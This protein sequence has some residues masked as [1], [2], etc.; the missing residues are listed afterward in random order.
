MEATRLTSRSQT[1]AFQTTHVRFKAAAVAILVL[2]AGTASAQPAGLT[3]LAFS[4]TNAPGTDGTF[5]SFGIQKLVRPVI[6]NN[7][8]VAFLATLTGGSV[9]SNNDQALYVIRNAT[10]PTI[11]TREG[12]ATSTGTITAIDSFVISNAAIAY[13]LTTNDGGTVLQQNGGLTTSTLAQTGLNGWLNFTVSQIGPPTINSN[14]NVAAVVQTT[15]GGNASR[16]GLMNGFESSL[17]NALS[18]GDAIENIFGAE[19]DSLQLVELPINDFNEVATTV[20]IKNAMDSSVVTGSVNDQII[21]TAGNQIANSTYARMASPAAGFI[22]G[23]TYSNFGFDTLT[24]QHV[25]LNNSGRPL[26]SAKVAGTGITLADDTA[27]FRGQASQVARLTRESSPA[28]GVGAG[29]TFAE[30]PPSEQTT[31]FFTNASQAFMLQNLGGAGSGNGIFVGDSVGF[32][33]VAFTGQQ[34]A[35]LPGGVGIGTITALAANNRN[36]AI[37]LATLTGPGVTTANDVALFLYSGSSTNLVAREGDTWNVNSASRT[38]ATIWINTGGEPDSLVRGGRMQL[39]DAGRAVF[40]ATFSDSSAGVFTYDLP[41][42]C[43]SLVS[44]PATLRAIEGT[45]A[46]FFG[47]ASAGPNS[48]QWRESGRLI[49]DGFEFANTTTNTLTM[50]RPLAAS[51]G[52]RFSL[53]A[54]NNCGTV[55]TNAAELTVGKRSDLNKDGTNDILW[56]NSSSGLCIGWTTDNTPSNGSFI[57]GTFSLP[58]VSDTNWTLA[59]Q[60]DFNFDGNIDLVWRNRVTG[61][62]AVWFMNGNTFSGAGDLPRVDDVNWDIRAVA[63]INS[64]GINDLVWRNS[65]TGSNVVWLMNANFGTINSAIALP[66]VSDVNWQIEAVT[67][68]NSDNKPDVLWRN[69]RSGD[70]ALWYL[71]GTS[72]VSTAD[73]S[74]AQIN[75]N[76]RVAAVADFDDDSRPDIMW[77]NTLTGANELW[78]MNGSTRTSV[79]AMPAVSDTSWRTIGQARFKSGAESDFNGDAFSDIFWRHSTNGQNLLWLMSGAN[80]GTAVPLEAITDNAWVVQGTSD[81]TRDNKPDVLWRNIVTGQNVL[82]VMNGL[83]RTASFDLPGVGNTDWYVGAIADVDGDE[84][85]DLVWM[86]DASGES[87]AWILDGTPLDGTWVRS[88]AFFPT[89]ANAS[90]NLRGSGDFNR[91][92]RFDLFFRNDGA[93]GGQGGGNEY[94]AMNR[95]TRLSIRTLTA[96]SDLNWDVR[97]VNDYNRDGNPDLLWHNN[98]SGTNLIWLMIGANSD[99]IGN[100]SFL[101][102]LTDTAW[103]IER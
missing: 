6:A 82:W 43:T 51:N 75:V 45:R 78:L 90:W 56:R 32:V 25:N 86:N 62:N 20:K 2:I 46:R 38:L 14:G 93:T 13:R 27:L 40:T 12:G 50:L 66:S 11:Q 58:T 47:G 30:F 4:G 83:T 5:S 77:R 68:F 96:V 103:R 22:S 60:G 59:S 55:G 35:D 95:E 88:L 23:I 73:V 57:T 36:Q 33:G 69:G 81:L 7:G 34:A 101:P 44:I 100:T 65:V 94:W 84:T 21:L 74:P 18:T 16:I 37:F 15:N 3:T 42:A 70:T 41:A 19:V 9:T 91:D 29:V 67:D 71:D 92:G 31:P 99:V 48:L 1:T 85:N 97:A 63:D 24:Q 49:N 53:D 79:E 76:F 28:P 102:E 54:S 39:N 10:D 98:S 17:F 89:Q 64:D 61:D 87:L 52:R 80:F 72:V 8:D 26:F